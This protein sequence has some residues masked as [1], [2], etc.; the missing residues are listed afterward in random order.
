MDIELVMAMAPGA[1]IYVFESPSYPNDVLSTM[2]N[3]TF[4]KQFSTSWTLG[5]GFYTGGVGSPNPAGD[6]LLMEMAAQGQSFFAASGDFDAYHQGPFPTDNPPSWEQ[7]SPYATV[8]GGTVLTMNGSGASYASET[9]WN[10]NPGGVYGSQVG[11]GGG[12][13]LNYATPYWQQGVSMTANHGSTTQRNIPDVAMVA[14]CLDVYVKGSARGGGGTSASAPLWAGFM[15]LVNQKA[16]S[17]GNPS[18]GFINPAIYAIGQGTGNTP[19]ASA[20]HDITTGNNFWSVS[21]NNYPAVAGYD[22]CTG[23]GTPAIGLINALAGPYQSVVL[24]TNDNGPG[25]LRQAISNAIAGAYAF[26]DITFATNLSGAT[27]LLTS[28]QLM[29]SSNLTIDASALPGGITINGSHTSRI[30]E[31]AGGASGKLVALSLTNGYSASNA[32]A[33]FN[34]G[35]LSLNNCTL[36]GNSTASGFGGG[37][38]VNSNLLTLTGCTFSGNGAGSGGAI[39]NQT[40]AC[41]VQNCTF[42]GNTASAGNGGAIDNAG[43]AVLNLLHCTFA[44]NTATSHGGDIYNLSR[45][46]NQIGR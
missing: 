25:S 15:A 6:V 4:I 40:A 9:V 23:W 5:G 24:N 41:T 14:V 10:P 8:V 19:Y 33:I 29:I 17:L 34:G 12:L 28:G 30:F 37:A 16:A 35:V 1:S 2:V 3:Y 32:G 27:I 44:G 20:F 11:S 31:I 38:I 22:L 7:E 42:A 36:A 39:L 46:V 18:A 26:S 21:P 13:S 43:S 45:Q